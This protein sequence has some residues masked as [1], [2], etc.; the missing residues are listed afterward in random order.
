[1]A[2]EQ[3]SNEKI[4]GETTSTPSLQDTSNYKPIL[5]ENI[6]EFMTN[7][8]HGTDGF[9]DGSYLIPH[10]REIFYD[11]RRDLAFYKNYFAPIINAQVDPVFNEEADREVIVNGVVVE[12]GKLVNTFLDNCDNA[13]TPLQSFVKD[14]VKTA[15]IH[16]VTFVVV[17]N[18]SDQPD[19]LQDAI[20]S[21]TLPYV[22]KKTAN[23]VDGY[24]ADMFG[25]L[26][27][28]RFFDREYK[29]KDESGR[30]KTVKEYSYWDNLEYKKQIKESAPM[31]QA[32]ATYIDIEVITHGLTVI[33]VIPLYTVVRE[34]K[35]I[36]LVSPPFYDIAKINHAIFN[37]D[38]E[39]RDQERAQGFALLYIPSDMTQT[40]NT[41]AGTSNVLWLPMDSPFPPDYAS[42]D[43]NILKGLMDN[44][45][46]LRE[47]L[48]RIAGQN[49]VVGVEK[50]QSGIA[51]QWDFIAHEMVLQATSRLA[52]WLEYRIMDIFKLYTNEEFEYH[53]MYPTDFQ[54]TAAAQILEDIDKVMLMD[55][56]EL[57]KLT[58]A[59]KAFKLITLGDDE[60]K[61][62][63]VLKEFKV[64]MENAKSIQE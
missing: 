3:P 41:V 37:K 20:N 54:P 13:K 25:N 26:L 36:I 28:I 14:A 48:F 18:F 52:E 16:G 17:D 8:Y 42:P 34:D 56:P 21:R 32:K 39:I 2:Q 33:P 53:V 38:S 29:T 7:A 12:E 44:G 59:E 51:K 58:L 30:T 46:M 57:A 22:Y 47:D 64:L 9:R 35:T 45:E 60:G 31:G 15:K 24:E 5:N 55:I 43:P 11:R 61:T 62:E 63:E 4:T 6:Y 19:N 50:Q 1:M 10:S 40:G 23:V 49:G 27:W